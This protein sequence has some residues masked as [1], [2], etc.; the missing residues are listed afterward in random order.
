[1]YCKLLEEV[2]KEMQNAGENINAEEE[3]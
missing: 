3:E 1:M 2:I